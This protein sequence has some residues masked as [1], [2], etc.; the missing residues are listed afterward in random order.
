M[1]SREHQAVRKIQL[2][3]SIFRIFRV[4][5]QSLCLLEID[6]YGQVTKGSH[7]GPGMGAHCF[8]KALG[9][10]LRYC[11]V[12]LVLVDT[13]HILMTREKYYTRCSNKIQPDLFTN[14]RDL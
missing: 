2:C 11:L 10:N 3:T 9:N 5:I 12:S 7:Y 4:H 8:L 13:D 14:F 1:Y 6:L